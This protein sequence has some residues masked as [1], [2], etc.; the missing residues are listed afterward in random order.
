M[1]DSLPRLLL[2]MQTIKYLPQ[3]AIDSTR[4]LSMELIYGTLPNKQ[5]KD[6]GSN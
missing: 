3:T 1:T 2:P 5:K 6:D 4:A